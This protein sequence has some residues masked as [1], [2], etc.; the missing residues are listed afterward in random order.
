MSKIAPFLKKKIVS[1][2]EWLPAVR[3]PKLVAEIAHAAPTLAIIA[4]NEQAF[5]PHLTTR[6]PHNKLQF[7]LTACNTLPEANTQFGRDG[8]SLSH[9][10]QYVIT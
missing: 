5:K 6:K 7:C 4:R 8:T 9:A 10:T 2:S 3:S 1:W